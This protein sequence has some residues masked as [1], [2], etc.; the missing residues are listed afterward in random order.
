MFNLGTI[1]ATHFAVFVIQILSA[2]ENEEEEEIEELLTSGNK[3]MPAG[4][5]NYTYQPH[6]AFEEA[7]THARSLIDYF[8]TY[9]DTQWAP[10]RT[11]DPNNFTKIKEALISDGRQFVSNSKHLVA[12]VAQASSCTDPTLVSKMAASIRTLAKIIQK[13]VEVLK[14]TIDD[15]NMGSVRECVVT[16]SEAYAD[17]LETSHKAAGKGIQDENMMMIMQKASHLASL[18]SLFL[19]TLRALH[20]PN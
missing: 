16:V 19:K 6:N 17:M 14:V 8:T 15:Y 10:S 3:I 4:I 9:C 7:M 20:E 12:G 5:L 11:P 2:M 18:L 1:A 13:G